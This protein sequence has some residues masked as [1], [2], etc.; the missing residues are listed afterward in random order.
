VTTAAPWAVGLA[1]GG[2]ACATT[3]AGAGPAPSAAPGTSAP[4]SRITASVFTAS[5]LVRTAIRRD[6]VV[7]SG[8]PGM[9][10][11][12]PEIALALGYRLAFC[13]AFHSSTY[14]C[15]ASFRNSPIF[16]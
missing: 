12:P 8:S 6:G 15:A 3:G 9:R 7:A 14:C 16:G 13:D 5:L 2:L 1:A 11:T 10:C 4:T